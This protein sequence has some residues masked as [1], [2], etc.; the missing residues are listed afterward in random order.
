MVLESCKMA[1]WGKYS[2]LKEIIIEFLK[3]DTEIDGFLDIRVHRQI[4]RRPHRLF[5]NT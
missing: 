3:G 4:P 5:T 1:T 2:N